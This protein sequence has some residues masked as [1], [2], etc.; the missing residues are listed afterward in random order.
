MGVFT[1]NIWFEK[2]FSVD[3]YIT[4]VKLHQL[5]G[6]PDYPLHKVVARV[7]GR[8]ENDDFPSPG[9]MDREARGGFVH[10]PEWDGPG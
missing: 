8:V 5:T 10:L 7:R 4:L 3:V 6:Q 9:W 1:L 2:K